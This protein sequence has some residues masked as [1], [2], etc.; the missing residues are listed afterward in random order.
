MPEL[1]MTVFI[2]LLLFCNHTCTDRDQ[3]PKIRLLILF[4]SKVRQETLQVG[5]TTL[6]HRCNS[7]RMVKNH[8]HQ[9]L[10][11][12][13]ALTKW[14]EGLA[15]WPLTWANTAPGGTQQCVGSSSHINIYPCVCVL[16]R[17]ECESS[18]HSHSPTHTH[19]DPSPRPPPGPPGVLT[20]ALTWLL[21]ECLF[22]SW[23][24][25]TIL[26][27]GCLSRVDAFPWQK[28]QHTLNKENPAGQKL[29]SQKRHFADWQTSIWV[30]WPTMTGESHLNSRK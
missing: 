5:I 21:V 7:A 19:P 1:K 3:Y 27:S 16:P 9:R 2:F 28:R 24:C 18:C 22:S 4:N 8:Q 23:R 12:P 25:G 10:L 14:G 6:D 20:R 17:L 13:A 29:Y 26:S 30:R 15:A 11:Q